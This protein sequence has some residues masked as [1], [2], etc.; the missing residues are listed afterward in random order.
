MLQLGAAGVAATLVKPAAGESSRESNDA[1][2]LQLHPAESAYL[3]AWQSQRRNNVA[4]CIFQRMHCVK[5]QQLRALCSAADLKPPEHSCTSSVAWPWNDLSD[6]DHRLREAQR[7]LI[8]TSP[9]H[10]WNWLELPITFRPEEVDFVLACYQ[11]VFD[12]II[13]YRHEP[14]V[15]IV[16]PAYAALARRLGEIPGRVISDLGLALANKR[17]VLFTELAAGP[18]PKPPYR[19]PWRSR[20]E[21]RDRW[22]ATDPLIL[23]PLPPYWTI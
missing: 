5:S 14:R 11:E 23:S 1:D 13:G 22:R 7:I 9:R 20:A 16:F 8:G 4:R 15:P 21:L 3:L 18:S 12:Y 6:L 2:I 10:Q 17:H 19:C